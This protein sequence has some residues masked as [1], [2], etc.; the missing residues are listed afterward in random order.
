M[1]NSQ[2]EPIYVKSLEDCKNL[3]QQNF[4]VTQL[5]R[6]NCKECNKEVVRNLRYVLYDSRWLCNQCKRKEYFRRNFG[7]DYLSQVPSVKE[8]KRKTCLEHFGVENPSQSASIQNKKKSTC[9]RKFGTEN[10]SKSDYFKKMIP[11]IVKKKR[12]NYR[13]LYGDEQFAKRWE[14]RR[15]AVALA[16]YGTVLPHS[17][18]YSYEDQYFDSS[19]ELAVWLWAKAK[20]KK[21]VR[22][23]VQLLYSYDGTEHTYFPDFKIEDMLIEIKGDYFF[24]ATGKMICPWNSEQNG[25][26]EAKQTCAK[27]NNVV[28]WTFKDVEPILDFVKNFYGLKNFDCYKIRKSK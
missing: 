16:K 14:E 10:V 27:E 12:A 8:K 18:R 22:E 5:L 19:W 3:E 17:S 4:K 6:L 20:N 23:P 28:F 11:D 7:V 1:K 2:K 21:I 9:L 15:K 25:L 26:F 24:D 13:K